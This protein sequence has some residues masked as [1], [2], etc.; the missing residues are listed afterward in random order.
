M[1]I[2]LTFGIELDLIPEDLNALLGIVSRIGRLIF[3]NFAHEAKAPSPSSVSA[4]RLIFSND[5]LA[6]A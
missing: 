5:V 4:G 1:P 3:S 6:N 2:V